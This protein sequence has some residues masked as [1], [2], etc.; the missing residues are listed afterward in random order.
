[1]KVFSAARYFPSVVDSSPREPRHRCLGSGNRRVL[2]FVSFFRTLRFCDDETMIYE[3]TS[4]PPP[5]PS[6]SHPHP[7][8]LNPNIPSPFFVHFRVLS[9]SQISI[10]AIG[11]D[12]V[13]SWELGVGFGVGGLLC[14][15]G[16]AHFISCIYL[17]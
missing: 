3:I 17:E 7:Q 11:W 16:F 1:M 15:G 9:T 14:R 6:P 12:R 10:Y 13:G 4:H 8:S 5:L 2:Y